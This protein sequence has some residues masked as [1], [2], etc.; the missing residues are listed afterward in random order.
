M[1]LIVRMR[2]DGTESEW[3]PMSGIVLLGDNQ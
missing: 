2:D 1:A 3:D